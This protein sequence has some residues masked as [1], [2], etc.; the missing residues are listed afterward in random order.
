MTLFS[1]ANHA[2]STRLAS[3]SGCR[4]GAATKLLI[5]NPPRSSQ[6]RWWPVKSVLWAETSF[7]HTHIPSV[8]RSCGPCPQNTK[9]IPSADDLLQPPLCP[10]H[11]HHHR[12]M[13]SL[14]SP[15]AWRAVC[16]SQCDLHSENVSLLGTD[17]QQHPFPLGATSL[18]EGP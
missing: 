7:F 4:M 14:P 16:S 15:L 17:V 8:S 3:P 5:F 10:T 2:R 12:W 18:C 9:T 13:T 11:F 6:I 1:P